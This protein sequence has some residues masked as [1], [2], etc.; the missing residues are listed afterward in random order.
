MASGGPCNL[1]LSGGEPTV[2][3]DLPDIVRL[4]RAAGF[5]FIQINTN[6]L[7][8]ATEP[9]YAA[10]LAEAGASSAFL[11]FDGTND[12]I[13]TALRGRA[14]LAGKLEAV[15]RLHR[16]GIG[17]VL[18]PT[19]KPGV[20]DHDLGAILRLAASLSP[21]VRG[22]HFQPVSYFGR[23][24][25]PPAAADR[26]TLPEI[27]RLLDVQT[28]GAASPAHFNPPGCEHALC[29][30]SGK[31]LVQPDGTLTPLSR[32]GPCGCTP[33]SAP[34]S[35]ADGAE[36][37]KSQVA[38]NWILPALPDKAVHAPGRT[39]DGLDLFLEN[40]R[41]RILTVSAMAFMDVWTLDLDRLRGCCIHVAT[42][43]GRRVPF[44]AHYL[45][46]MDGTKLYQDPGEGRL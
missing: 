29:S 12:A 25:G 36:R 40:A 8:L 30:F 4:A 24:P 11:Q 16:A 1:Q 31:Y 37:A 3:D 34:E 13:F 28:G 22:V 15:T 9:D 5:T 2:R 45:T 27:M 10:R 14:L 18:V 6:G 19:V 44:C 23:Y 46:A 26:I 38:A 41:T 39:P 43:D 7:R 21:A 32:S 17:A 33:G 42:P 35:A 20:N